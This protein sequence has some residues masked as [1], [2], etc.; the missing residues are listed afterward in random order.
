MSTESIIIGLNAKGKVIDA[1]IASPIPPLL[2]TYGFLFT[3]SAETHLNG[4]INLLKSY[5]AAAEDDAKSWIN[6]ISIG[7]GDIRLVGRV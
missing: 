7:Y 5:S 2:K 3:I 4:T 6:A 1:L